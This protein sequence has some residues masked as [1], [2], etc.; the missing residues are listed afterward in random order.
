MLTMVALSRQ[1]EEPHWT[2]PCPYLTLLCL[3]GSSSRNWFMPYCY[4]LSALHHYLCLLNFFLF[5]FTVHSHKSLVV[6]L[7]HV[8]LVDNTSGQVKTHCTDMVYSRAVTRVWQEGGCP[9]CNVFLQV[10]GSA[11]PNLKAVWHI[12]PGFW[13][14]FCRHW[15]TLI[16]SKPV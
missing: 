12:C 2:L 6:T 7:L 11:E 15:S 14:N 3:H 4:L 5:F 8:L 9:G 1:F 10:L 16:I 13:M